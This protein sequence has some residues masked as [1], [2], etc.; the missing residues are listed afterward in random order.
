MSEERRQ[1]S[2]THSDGVFSE[3]SVAVIFKQIP[4]NDVVTRPNY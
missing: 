3:V 2:H 1:G 4:H